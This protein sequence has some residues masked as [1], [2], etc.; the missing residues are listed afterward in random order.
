M[1]IIFYQTSE[2]KVVTL[3]YVVQ[4]KTIVLFLSYFIHSH[5][6]DMC[7]T[8]VKIFLLFAFLSLEIYVCLLSARSN[9]VP[10]KCP[11]ECFKAVAKTVRRK[12]KLKNLSYCVDKAVPCLSPRGDGRGSEEVFF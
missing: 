8:R 9:C 11:F 6:L 5:F 10:Q 12:I 3:K 1:N 7:A 4:V 2:F